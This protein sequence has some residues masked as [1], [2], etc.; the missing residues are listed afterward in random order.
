MVHADQCSRF[1]AQVSVSYCAEAAAAAVTRFTTLINCCEARIDR[2]AAAVGVVGQAY[3]SVSVLEFLHI[4]H[5][6]Q[7]KIVCIASLFHNDSFVDNL[8]YIVLQGRNVQGGPG[9]WTPNC[10]FGQLLGENFVLY[11]H[12]SGNIK[13]ISGTN[14]FKTVQRL[15]SLHINK[16]SSVQEKQRFLNT[17]SRIQQKEE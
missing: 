16:L 3:D 6:T 4:A 14:R 12:V 5:F 11:V 7:V 2:C 8:I 15:W 17:C 1:A 13:A 9:V 10:N